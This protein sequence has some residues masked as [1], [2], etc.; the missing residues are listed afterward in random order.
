MPCLR[1][2]ED[3]LNVFRFLGRH[4]T[5]NIRVHGVWVMEYGY[6]IPS[7]FPQVF[8][9]LNSKI[10]RGGIRKLFRRGKFSANILNGFN[11]LIYHRTNLTRTKTTKNTGGARS[12]GIH[13]GDP[14]SI[15]NYTVKS[16]TLSLN[17]LTFLIGYACIERQ[18]FAVRQ[19]QSSVVFL[20][21]FSSLR[22]S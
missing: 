18:F 11:F 8:F 7:S 13:L 16:L 2:V 3:K 20:S 14:T 9:T 17:I 22:Y 21:Q 12:H 6:N 10:H 15:I 5:V 4:V 1:S 19:Y